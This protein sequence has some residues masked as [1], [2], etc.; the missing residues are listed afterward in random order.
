[1]NTLKV[2]WLL[3]W[4]T[5]KDVFNDGNQWSH[6]IWSGTLGMLLQPGWCCCCWWC[7]TVHCRSEK[8]SDFLRPTSF[9]KKPGKPW[10]THVAATVVGGT[11][12]MCSLSAC[13]FP[14]VSKKKNLV[15]E[16][17]QSVS[18]AVPVVFWYVSKFVPDRICFSS[19]Q[20]FFTLQNFQRPIRRWKQKS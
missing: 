14:M 18:A 17:W 7:F 6:K 3:H 5:P 12:Q 16:S 1:M 20:K 4:N 9:L 19:H 8:Y 2:V 10:Y 11:E 15:D 13:L